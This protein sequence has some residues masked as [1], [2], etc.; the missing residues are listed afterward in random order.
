MPAL[1]ALPPLRWQL[2]DALTPTLSAFAPHFAT[3]VG[4]RRQPFASFSKFISRYIQY[5]PGE[6]A[7]RVIRFESLRR[8]FEF[9]SAAIDKALQE[10]LSGISTRWDKPNTRSRT[11]LVSLAT[12]LIFGAAA[13]STRAEDLYVPTHFATV[14]AALA[15]A[16][17]DRLSPNFSPSEEI[18]I[19]VFSGRYAETLPL[20]LDVPNLRL[21][22]ETNLITDDQ[23][24]PTGFVHQTETQ[25]IAY[26]PVTGVQTIFL[27]G[28]TSSV[29]TGT[30]VTVE[31]FV[32]DAGNVKSAQDGR[33]ITI[34]RA[35]DFSIRRNVLT[36]SAALAVDA[37]ASSGTIEENLIDGNGCGAC[38]SAGNKATPARYSFLRNRSVKNE[39][40]G[41]LVSGSSY[42]GVQSPAL[43]PPSPGTVF[44]DVTADVSDNDVSDNNRYPTFSTGIRLF[45]ILPGI[46]AAQSTG[47]LKA[48]VTNNTITNNSFGVSIDAGFPF[49]T[50]TR[51]WS[52]KFQTTFFG[53]TI[54]AST[55]AAALIT[56][57]R[58]TTALSRKELKDYK[59]LQD[60]TIA[61]TDW[62]G[63]LSGYWFDNPATDPMDGRIL[64]NKLTVNGVTIPNGRNFSY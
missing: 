49:R 51:L 3:F 52:A 25:L 41:V 27:I 12:F 40:A 36:G 4:I 14:Q 23:G 29:L 20:I 24:L 55:T 11:S 33:D 44:D 22:G 30:R 15:K 32:L 17:S 8:H 7:M 6:N 13:V 5:Q 10:L 31:G 39:L 2:F 38:L 61:I 46:P 47:K 56:F 1:L 54:V 19:H 50:D 42:D 43:V 16:R 18:V 45:A 28:P 34:D 53:N 57:T 64:N 62:D 26:P 63:D 60:S 21:K 48:T 58:N 9:D 35:Q 59:Y 37:R